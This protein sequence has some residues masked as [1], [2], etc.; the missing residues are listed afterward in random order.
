MAGGI[1]DS[2]NMLYYL[3][4]NIPFWTMSPYTFDSWLVAYNLFVNS[5]GDLR[6]VSVANTFGVRPVIN[7]DPGK[8]EFSG[9]G[10]M[11]D[12]YILS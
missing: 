11:S 12:P 10:T 7:I 3:Y 2:N 9:N 6:F 4:T 8:I 1:K 5:T